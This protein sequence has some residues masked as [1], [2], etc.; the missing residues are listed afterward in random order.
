MTALVKVVTPEQYQAW[1]AAQKQAI[2]TADGQVSSLRQTLT[3]Q[4]NLG[5]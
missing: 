3:A 2:S 4:G 5:N 1:I